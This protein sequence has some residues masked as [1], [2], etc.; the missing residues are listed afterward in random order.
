MPLAPAR[1]GLE[2]DP[3]LG[4]ATGLGGIAGQSE[5]AGLH[6]AQGRIQHGGDLV[7][8]L[9]GFDV[10][11]ETDHVAPIAVGREKRRGGGAVARFQRL[12]QLRQP[13]RD[14]AVRGMNV[15]VKDPF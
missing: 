13:G 6:V 14:A 7:A 10:P 11:G 12:R 4:D 5:V 1:G 3:T 2:A 8:A 9:H 15:H